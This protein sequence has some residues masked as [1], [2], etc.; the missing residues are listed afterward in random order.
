MFM[1]RHHYNGQCPSLPGIQSRQGW[2]STNFNSYA[3]AS[4]PITIPGSTEALG[5][6]ALFNN[7]N[8]IEKQWVKTN[9][10]K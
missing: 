10:N 8:F 1:E 9:P 3:Q 6:T 2:F 5:N 7:S 4:E